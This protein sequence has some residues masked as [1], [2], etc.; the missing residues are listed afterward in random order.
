[1]LEKQVNLTD[2]RIP[3]TRGCSRN[4]TDEFKL[5][6]LQAQQLSQ[7]EQ[8]H[9][10]LNSIKENDL[11]VFKEP[12]PVKKQARKTP[13]IQRITTPSKNITSNLTKTPVKSLQRSAHSTPRN[14][15]KNDKLSPAKTPKPQTSK[16]Q[17]NSSNLA[18]L[19]YKPQIFKPSKEIICK[20]SDKHDDEAAKQRWKKM[21]EMQSKKGIIP[22]SRENETKSRIPGYHSLT[23]T[24]KTPKHATQQ[25][26]YNTY[27]SQKKK[28]RPE[29]HQALNLSV[30]TF[31]SP[32]DSDKNEDR[33]P[34]YLSSSHNDEHL[35]KKP[36]ATTKEWKLMQWRSS[37]L[38]EKEKRQRKTVLDKFDRKN[39]KSKQK[40]EKK[41][42]SVP[43]EFGRNSE[44]LGHKVIG[45]SVVQDIV[46]KACEIAQTNALE[47]QINRIKSTRDII[48]LT[49]TTPVPQD[50]KQLVFDCK[51]FLDKSSPMP[52]LVER[53]LKA[54]VEQLNSSTLSYTVYLGYKE[55]LPK[56]LFR[57]YDINHPPSK[58]EKFLDFWYELYINGQQQERKRFTFEHM[59]VIYFNEIRQVKDTVE[60]IKVDKEI[61]AGLEIDISQQEQLPIVEQTPRSPESKKRHSK[62]SSKRHSIEKCVV[63]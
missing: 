53:S 40:S 27:H 51:V 21:F 22:K 7:E 60:T 50:S 34:P 38:K 32:T 25:K 59:E 15:P 54:S 45:Y 33:S 37:S 24:R 23:G 61:Q 12:K 46:T 11:N 43:L 39:N 3:L 36:K 47:R 63:M 41:S 5:L 48:C 2:L 19:N 31:A 14:S 56:A 6:E 20:S 8:N 55:P 10:T 29:L 16:S 9:I 62:R 18:D 42:H 57:R 44:N 52:V 1:M 28:T 49:G 35:F 26:L 13:N 30:S 4:S 17:V 58:Y